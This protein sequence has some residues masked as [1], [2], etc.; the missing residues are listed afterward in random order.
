[1]KYLSQLTGS[2]LVS[3][4]WLLWSGLTMLS[5]DT[6]SDGW[7]FICLCDLHLPYLYIP[8][9]KHQLQKTQFVEKK[10]LVEKETFFYNWEFSGDFEKTMHGAYAQKP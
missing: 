4:K 2:Y 6:F 7:G 9:F 8:D 3:G 5:G 1:M 10:W